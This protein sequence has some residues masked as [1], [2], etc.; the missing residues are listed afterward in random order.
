MIEPTDE[1]VQA[2][3]HAFNEEAAKMAATAPDFIEGG[4]I[5]KAGLAAVLAIVE[6]DWDVRK[7]LC[8]QSNPHDWSAPCELWDGHDGEHRAEVRKRVHW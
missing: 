7:P 1:M 4:V 2:F 5:T 8:L 6:R 3:R